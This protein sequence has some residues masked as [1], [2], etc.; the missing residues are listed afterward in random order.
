[1]KATGLAAM[2]LALGAVPACTT[3]LGSITPPSNE[4][5]TEP[6]LANDAVLREILVN[7]QDA[8]RAAVIAAQPGDAIILANGEWTDFDLVFEATGTEQNPILLTAQEPGKVILTGQSSLR[9]GGQFLVV[10]GLVFRDG[11]TPLNEVIS[12]RR[13]SKTLAFNSRVTNTV[14]ENYSNPDRTQRDTWVVM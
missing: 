13:D 4:T 11:Y 1:M 8:F 2:L 5:L 12:F 3:P 14:I 9:L 10:S 6:R 7:D